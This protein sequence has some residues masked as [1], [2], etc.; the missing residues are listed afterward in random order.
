[1][2]HH[3]LQRIQPGDTVYLVT[4]GKVIDPK[5][6]IEIKARVLGIKAPG[7]DVKAHGNMQIEVVEATDK[8]HNPIGHRFT[9]N[10]RLWFNEKEWQGQ[11]ALNDHGT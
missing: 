9:T 2:K 10:S 4:T 5:G 6:K 8:E 7:R 11:Q 3:E 1:M